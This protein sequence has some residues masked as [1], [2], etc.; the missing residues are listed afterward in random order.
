M[1]FSPHLAVYDTPYESWLKDTLLPKLEPKHQ[2]TTHA[3]TGALIFR[4]GSHGT[5]NRVLLV[6]RAATDSMPNRW[7]VPG[8]ACDL[9]DPSIFH[10]LAREVREETG[11][12]VKNVVDW[13]DGSAY[14][15]GPSDAGGKKGE[16]DSMY[17]TDEAIKGHGDFFITSTKKLKVVKLSFWVEVEELA[18]DGEAEVQVKLDPNEHSAHAWV[19]EEEILSGEK[20]ELTAEPQK[21]VILKGFEMVRNK[22]TGTT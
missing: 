8:G 10:S 17:L 22:G 20:Y 1:L 13:V 9:E 11:L 7:E 2:D 4:Y 15:D 14:V 6:R 19:T 18:R 3:A 16:W 5:P 21:K 12:T